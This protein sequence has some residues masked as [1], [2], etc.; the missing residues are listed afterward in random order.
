MMLQKRIFGLLGQGKTLLS[1]KYIV[2][3]ADVLTAHFRHELNHCT[4]SECLQAV[5]FIGL[6]RNYMFQYI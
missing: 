3:Q 2:Q 6:S 5:K 4:Q 1:K